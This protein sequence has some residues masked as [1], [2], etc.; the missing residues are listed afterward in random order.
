[1][2]TKII[3]IFVVVIL[4]AL[5]LLAVK[6]HIDNSVVDKYGMVKTPE[7]DI[8]LCRYSSG[9][10]MDG[11]NEIL[12]IRQ[13]E[14]GGTVIT[15][16]YTS[17]TSDKEI[18]KSVEAPF[19][20]LKEIRDICKKYRIFSWGKLKKSEE[21]ILDAPVSSI[22]IFT[23]EVEYS[24]SNTDEIPENAWGI[25]TEIYNIMESYIEGVD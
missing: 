5:S 8:I 4:I 16:D 7:D 23:G 1:M 18:S 12:E 22:Y 14:N 3:I 20:P 21:F 24:F 11:S 10:G 19:T 2:K 6:K 9:G 17:L 13:S 15:Y 25:T